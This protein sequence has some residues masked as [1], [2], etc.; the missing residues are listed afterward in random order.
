MH[1]GT[2]SFK[3]QK[4]RGTAHCLP[5]QQHGLAS[6]AAI[7]SGYPAD[8]KAVKIPPAIPMGAHK[9]LRALTL[10]KAN[11]PPSKMAAVPPAPAQRK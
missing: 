3:I 9:A 6:C 7:D 1:A 10:L 4:Q 2:A 5:V 8:K 11:R